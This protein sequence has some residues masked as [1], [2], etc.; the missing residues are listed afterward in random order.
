MAKFLSRDLAELT[1][2]LIYAPSARRLEQIDRAEHLYWQ[3]DPQ[4]NYPLQY[5][6][7][8][9]T[10]YRLDTVEEVMLTGRAVRHD[11]L[12]M[13]RQLSAS[14]DLSPDAFDPAPMETAALCRQLKITPKTL[15]RYQKAGLFCRRI[16]GESGRKRTM[17]L[18]ASIDRFM[19]HRPATS[20]AGR[21]FERID[22]ATRHRILQRSRRIAL[23]IETSPF[24]VARH[25]GKKYRRTTEAIRL[26]LIN[27]DRRHS[28][29]PIFPRHTDPL[30]DKQQRVIYRAFRRGISVIQ[31]AQRFGRARS[32]IYR[33]VNLQRVAALSRIE[34]RWVP[35]P[36]FSMPDAEEVILGPQLQPAAGNLDAKTEAAL[37]SRLNYL[38]YRAAELRSRLDL[39][40]PRSTQLDQVETYLRHAAALKQTLAG[41]Y[42]RLVESVARK[43]SGTHAAAPSDQATDLTGL[44]NLVLMEALET[45]DA[46]REARFSTYLTWALMRRFAPSRAESRRSAGEIHLDSSRLKPP[47]ASEINTDLAQLERDEQA[48]AALAKLLITLSD[49]ERFILVHRFGP[50]AAGI[51]DA[52]PQPL[53]QIAA[54]LKITAERARQIERQ[55]LAKLRQSAEALGFS[56]EELALE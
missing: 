31:L 18:P 49:R 11:L 17:Y 32:A 20:R 7:W 5:I 6:A 46:G 1:R 4:L 41:S 44:G 12:L 50:K 25:L 39:L 35:S 38:K 14:L 10:R 13:V 19:A 29:D 52:A 37:F 9:I 54:Q 8:R 2:Q 47:A 30:S 34:I 3:T 48:D 42:L 45:F 33:A 23:R 55:A 43:H 24:A 56:L 28:D 27:H 26:M 16:V 51:A 22:P 40:H 36:T 15:S 53:A 21:G